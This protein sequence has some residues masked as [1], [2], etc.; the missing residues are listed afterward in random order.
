MVRRGPRDSLRRLGL[1]GGREWTPSNGHP[2]IVRLDPPARGDRCA[3]PA[4]ASAGTVDPGRVRHRDSSFGVARRV[5][6][7]RGAP[8]AHR[9]RARHLDLRQ[10]AR[11]GR[12]ARLVR[13]GPATDRRRSACGRPHG[14]DRMGRVVGSGAP[15]E[16]GGPRPRR[17]QRRRDRHLRGVMVCPPAGPARAGVRRA[18]AGAAVSGV[19]GYLGGHLAAARKVGSHHPAFKDDSPCGR[20]RTCER[21]AR[22]DSR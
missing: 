16:A 20:R 14:L 9:R 22:V 15:R 21:S 19:G 3:R 18:L 11:P 13:R 12:R 1:R 2:G 8:T 4:S 10:P 6:R 17:D 5:A 7:P